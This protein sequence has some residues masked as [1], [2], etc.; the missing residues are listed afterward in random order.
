MNRQEKIFVEDRKI[1]DQTMLLGGYQHLVALIDD[2]RHSDLVTVLAKLRAQ[3]SRKADPLIQNLLE[4]V[5]HLCMAW[6]HSLDSLDKPDRRHSV[7][8]NRQNILKGQLRSLCSSLQRIAPESGVPVDQSGYRDPSHSPAALFRNLWRR[9]SKR[10][11]RF[12]GNSET[13]TPQKGSVSSQ[14]VRPNENFPETINKNTQELTV[15]INS[16]IFDNEYCMNV[17]F[18]GSFRVCI[19]GDLITD[20]RNGK[21][22]MIFKYLVAHNRCPLSKELIMEL[23]W[24]NTDLE[25]ARNNLNVSIYNMRQSLRYNNEKIPCIIYNDG[26]YGVN[27]NLKIWTDFDEFLRIVKTSEKYAAEGNVERETSTL[28]EL[29]ELYVGDFLEEDRFEDWVLPFR[30]NFKDTYIR[31][32]CKR[33]DFYFDQEKYEHCIEMCKKMALIDPCDEHVHG[34]LMMCYS[35]LGHNHLAMRQFN[36]CVEALAGELDLTPDSTT[37]DLYERI[38]R[39]ASV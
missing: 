8:V 6:I 1:A 3:N 21:S 22:K 20:W 26:Q 14:D 33:A 12:A 36:C 23:L 15:K 18:F 32:M 28:K 13:L 39:H 4:S 17:Y 30:Q 35:R 24:P 34:R 11:R 19:N 5:Y 29:E 38:R 7:G 2:D 27:G 25:Y 31:S 9:I 37:I 16:K 10:I